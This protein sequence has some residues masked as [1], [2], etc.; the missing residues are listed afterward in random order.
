[1]LTQGAYK[2]T[3]LL[4]VSIRLGVFRPPSALHLWDRLQALLVIAIHCTMTV[5]PK[6]ALLYVIMVKLN[7]GVGALVSVQ[8]T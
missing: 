2:E 1:M 6:M 8:I 5:T 7:Y 4:Y 3:S